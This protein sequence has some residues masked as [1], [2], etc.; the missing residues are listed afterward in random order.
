VLTEAEIARLASAYEERADKASGAERSWWL[1]AKAIVS[2]RSA[3][4]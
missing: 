3:R 1:V 4:R 2:P